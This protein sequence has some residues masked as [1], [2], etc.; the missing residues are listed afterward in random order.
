MYPFQIYTLKCIHSLMN[1]Y[2]VYYMQNN[3]LICGDTSEDSGNISSQ[4]PYS[5]LCILRNLF[6]YAE[7]DTTEQ[8]S[9]EHT[10]IKNRTPQRQGEKQR[11]RG[12]QVPSGCS[13]H[14]CSAVLKKMVQDLFQ[15]TARLMTS[16]LL[17][18]WQKFR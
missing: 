1:I 12:C 14:P 16:V 6:F 10:Q 7:M 8:L 11:E 13:M 2:Y 17:R 18:S 15:K 3:M 5:R 9:I 4:Q